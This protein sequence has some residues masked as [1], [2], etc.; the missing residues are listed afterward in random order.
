[1]FNKK[2]GMCRNCNYVHPKAGEATNVGQGSPAVS[3]PLSPKL[4]D[5]NHVENVDKANSSNVQPSANHE[6]SSNHDISPSKQVKF[7]NVVDDID[8]NDHGHKHTTEPLKEEPTAAQQHHHR[9][10]HQ[11]QHAPANHRPPT[12]PS[13]S[14]Q[15]SPPKSSHDDHSRSNGNARVEHINGNSKT[16]H[17]NGHHP[18]SKASHHDEED[19]D[20]VEDVPAKSFGIRPSYDGKPSASRDGKHA[21]PVKSSNPIAK[22]A[23]KLSTRI[24]ARRPSRGSKDSSGSNEQPKPVAA[25]LVRRKSSSS[26]KGRKSL[27]KSIDSTSELG[28]FEEGVGVGEGGCDVYWLFFICCWHRFW[29]WGSL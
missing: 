16:E 27:R 12:P 8:R 18:A 17:V 2:P 9:D 1:M 24:S 20:V 11:H 5:T 4:P 25:D 7:S 26:I 22:F 19:D 3:P 13:S 28:R 29:G 21:D 14:M 10:D 6:A 23:R 15:Q